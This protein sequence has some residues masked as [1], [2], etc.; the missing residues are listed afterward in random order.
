VRSWLH[1]A[2]CV[3]PHSLAKVSGAKG[4]VVLNVVLN[5]SPSGQYFDMWPQLV[6]A[7]LC[8][9][10]AQAQPLLRE[11]S[12]D[13]SD[14]QVCGFP[15]PAVTRRCAGPVITDAS[16]CNHMRCCWVEQLGCVDSWRAPTYAVHNRTEAEQ[17]IKHVLCAIYIHSTYLCTASLSSAKRMTAK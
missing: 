16:V 9:A 7:A 15:V 6:V 2:L 13:W 12:T 17:V 11:W 3:E 14:V 1:A 10:M 5:V 4:H 8:G